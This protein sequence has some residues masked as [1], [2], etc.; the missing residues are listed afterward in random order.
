MRVNITVRSPAAIGLG[1]IFALGTA[2]VL[3]KDVQSPYDVTIDHMMTALVLLGTIA[4]GHLLWLALEDRRIVSALGLGILFV[5]G[6]LYCVVTSAARNAE[7]TAAEKVA[8]EHA[9]GVYK[10][11]KEAFDKA[12]KRYDEALQKETEEC[13]TGIGTRCEAKRNISAQRLAEKQ[14]AEAYLNSLPPPRP[15]GDGL[16]HAATVLAAIPGVAVGAEQIERWLGLILPFVKALFLEIGTSV[17]FGF[18]LGH[19]RVQVEAPAQEAQPAVEQKVDTTKQ[20]KVK[21]SRQ[22]RVLPANVVELRP[23]QK[24]E[25]R[26]W[27]RVVN[28]LASLRAA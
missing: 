26:R 3:L 25:A 14:A 1:V 6:T 23:R 20:R 12:E 7:V 28:Q 21:T 10:R 16:R 5:G 22:R 11:A 19:K 13:G 9:N 27:A 4:A 18:G 8:I 15:E 2:R 17:F 24:I